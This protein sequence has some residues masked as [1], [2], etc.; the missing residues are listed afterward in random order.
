M[1][2][3]LGIGA[4]MHF[5]QPDPIIELPADT[6]TVKEA[7][8]NVKEATQEHAEV[9]KKIDTEKIKLKTKVNVLTDQLNRAT[10]IMDSL[11]NDPVPEACVDLEPIK[12][13]HKNEVALYRA[14]LAG[15]DSIIN[16]DSLKHNA[17][18]E[19]QQRLYRS[20]SDLETNAVVS[21]NEAEHWKKKA[22]NRKA[23]T[24]GV[25]AAAVAAIL[26]K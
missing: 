7:M 3:L 25:V 19:L 12:E 21:A 2:L 9:T 23:V 17:A 22:R 5:N 26:L 18:V 11:L 20:I 6:N 8:N 15:K 4:Y 10:D 14:T 16:L 13:A 24:I 1:I